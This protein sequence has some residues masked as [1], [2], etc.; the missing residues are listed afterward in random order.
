MPGFPLTDEEYRAKFRPL[1][2]KA[3]QRAPEMMLAFRDELARGPVSSERFYEM[4]EAM[5]TAGDPY[6]A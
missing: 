1:F 6:D 4:C 5:V 3:F 2:E